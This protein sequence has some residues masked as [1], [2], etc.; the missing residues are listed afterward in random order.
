MSLKV[1]NEQNVYHININRKHSMIGMDMHDIILAI[2]DYINCLAATHVSTCTEFLF[3]FFLPLPRSITVRF[4]IGEICSTQ[5][6][7]P[8][9]RRVRPC[10]TVWRPEQHVDNANDT[11]SIFTG[12]SQ[13][14]PL[15]SQTFVFA[16]FRGSRRVSLQR[17]DGGGAVPI[18]FAVGDKP[19]SG[20]ELA[21]IFF[22]VRTQIQ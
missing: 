9:R 11:L 3:S 7:Q 2:G 6:R 19:K 14:D 15:I 18:G 21:I 17:L 1:L 20:H 22:F 16:L 4:K 10:A 12:G 8:D 5:Y 13:W